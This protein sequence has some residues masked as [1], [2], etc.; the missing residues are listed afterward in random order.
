MSDS[1]FFED[2]FHPTDDGSL[3]G[4][5]LSLGDLIPKEENAEEDALI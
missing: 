5:F 4:Q 1:L 3:A 2:D